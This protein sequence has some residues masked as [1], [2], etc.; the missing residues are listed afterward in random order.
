MAPRTKPDHEPLIRLTSV[1][2]TYDTG[3]VPFT[4]LNG[5]DLTVQPG[6]FVG[7]IGKSGSGKTTLINMITG[8]D[9]PTSG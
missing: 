9:R 2:K 6:E 5:V 4:A 8:I 1:V 3:E 7:L